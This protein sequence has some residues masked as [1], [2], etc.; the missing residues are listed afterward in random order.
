MDK[1]DFPRPQRILLLSIFFFLFLFSTCVSHLEEAK[2]S[3]TMAENYS[4]QYETEKAVAFY[5]KALEKATL[6]AK[7]RPSPQAYLLKG[8]AEL[9]LKRWKDAR[10]S[11]LRAFSY[12]FEKGEE[13]AHETSLMGLAAVLEKFGMEAAVLEVYTNI[14]DSSK[15][16]Q[17]SIYA[18]QRYMEIVLGKAVKSA[19]EEREKLLQQALRITEKLIRKDMSCGFYHYLKSQVLGHLS[20]Y[21]KSFEEAVMARELGLPSEKILRDNDLQVVFCYRMLKEQLS[22][23]EWEEFSSMYAELM[24]RWGWPDPET[25]SWKEK[26]EDASLD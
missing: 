17:V 26:R 15:L 18:A 24:R 22:G 12:G 16:R 23:K 19:E 1:K 21:R 4:R 8:M 2:L 10:E 5:K 20:D 7:K 9:E 14:L 11:F 3:F 6:E 13:W 25:P